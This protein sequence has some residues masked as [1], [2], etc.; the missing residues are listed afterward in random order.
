MINFIPEAKDYKRPKV[1]TILAFLKSKGW[2]YLGN[3]GAFHTLQSPPEIH[4]QDGSK[5]KYYVPVSETEYRYDENTWHLVRSIAAVYRMELQAAFDFFSKDVKEK[6]QKQP[7]QVKPL[8]A[9]KE[10]KESE[11]ALA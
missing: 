10:M 2:A 1:A 11:L 9:K 7:K 8:P 4:W 5:L 3:D 6:T